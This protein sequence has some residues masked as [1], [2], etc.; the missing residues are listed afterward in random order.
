VDASGGRRG[1]DEF[2]ERLNLWFDKTDA[3][4]MREKDSQRVLLDT[5]A[6]YERLDDEERNLADQ[7]FCEWV[8]MDGTG[9]QF[10]ALWLIS[11]HRMISALPA[12]RA[13]ARRF[14]VASGPS[15]PYDWAKV[16]RIIG[17]L[18]EA[19]PNQF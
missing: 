4:R 12:L 11:F 9:R 1:L 8:A 10:V 15:A 5:E 19:H 7:V 17:Q 14:E 16:N 18:A 2:R 3:L 13:A 6:F